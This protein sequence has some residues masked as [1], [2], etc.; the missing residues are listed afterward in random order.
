MKVQKEKHNRIGTCLSCKKAV[1][2]GGEK[3]GRKYSHGHI[4]FGC[5]EEQKKIVERWNQDAKR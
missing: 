2:D 5:L 4:H 3:A 1:Y